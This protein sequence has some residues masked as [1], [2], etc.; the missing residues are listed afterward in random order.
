VRFQAAMRGCAGQVL[1][2]TVTD[3]PNA[4]QVLET[5]TRKRVVNSKVEIPFPNIP[6]FW[7]YFEKITDWDRHVLYIYRRD[8]DDGQVAKCTNTLLLPDGTTHLLTGKEETEFAIGKGW[9]GKLYELILKGGP[10]RITSTKIRVAL[11]PKPI[12]VPPQNQSA[13]PNQ[14]SEGSATADVAH[15]AMGIIASQEKQA[16]DV[17]VNALKGAADV[18]QRL[19]QAQNPPAQP[20]QTDELMKMMMLKMMEKSLNPADPLELLKS[21]LGLQAQLNPQSATNPMLSRIMDAAVEKILNPAPAGPVSSASA[22]LVRQLPVVANYVTQAI[23]EWRAGVE[24]QRD[25]A[26]IMTHQKP[27]TPQTSNVRILPNPAPQVVNPVPTQPQPEPTP[28]GIPSLEFIESKIIE[29]LK[30]PISADEAADETLA[31]LSRMHPTLVTQLVQAG[32]QGLLSLFQQRPVLRPGLQNLPRL[33]E[34]VKSFFKYAREN[35]E[36]EKKNAIDAKPN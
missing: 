6:D 1:R 24:A 11:P 4:G 32:E 34:F 26:A 5:V 20:S 16:V 29:I 30:E 3:I 15:H 19:S 27:P 2:A 36:E 7:E 25:T 28:A 18:V 23:A 22:E 17:A 35:E 13:N 21:V 8:P 12:L 9:G 14:F 10:Q 31:F 33:Q